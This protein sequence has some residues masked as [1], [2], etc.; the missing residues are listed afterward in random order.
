MRIAFSKKSIIGILSFLSAALGFHSRQEDRLIAGIKKGDHDS[1][2]M[3][4]SLHSTSLRRFIS[5]RVGDADREDIFQETWVSAWEKLP[6]FDDRGKFRAWLL[7]IAFR[8]IQ[9]YHRR[10]HVRPKLYL[11]TEIETPAYRESGFQRIELQSALRG[12]WDSCSVE[13][14]EILTMYYSDE[15][16]LSE[17]ANIMGRNLNT[18]KYQ[19]YKIHNEALKTLPSDIEPL[20]SR[21]VMA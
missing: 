3:L 10:E 6:N 14:Q 15:L 17:I 8:R 5:R 21:E 19:F 4:Q 9:D 12:F 2:E 18:L 16:T 20:L 1:F 13:Q 11:S 7:T